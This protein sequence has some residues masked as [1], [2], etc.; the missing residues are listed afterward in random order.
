MGHARM[1]GGDCRR[2]GLAATIA[3]LIL[4]VGL[5][6]GPAAADE[7][8]AIDCSATPFSFSEEGFFVD[9]LRVEARASKDGASG[10]ST[11]DLINIASSERSMFLT[12]ISRRLT[13]VRM[14][15]RRQDLRES[16]RNVFS[17][18]ELNGWNGIGNKSGY[19]MA[20]FNAEISGQPS[21]CIALQRYL[22]PTNGGFK[23]QVIGVGCAAA[24]DLAPV[25]AA[26]S[27]LQAPGD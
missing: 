14:H 20:E 16:M 12:V 7:E 13:A 21:H 9:C 15:M 18:I 5:L 25:Y 19:D 2:T 6:A 26:L 10:L 1:E 27:K 22:N 4:A 24:A 23:R 11:S 8:G 3:G 17:S